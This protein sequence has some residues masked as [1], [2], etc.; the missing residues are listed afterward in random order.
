M[1]DT[2]KPINISRY[3]RT[4]RATRTLLLC[5]ALSLQS[6]CIGIVSNP[7]DTSEGGLLGF[8]GLLARTNRVYVAVGANGAAYTSSDGLTWEQSTVVADTSID[9]ED[10]VWTGSRFIAV[11]GSATSCG[12]FLSADGRT[13]ENVV[14]PSCT[15]RLRGVAASSDGTRV[16]TV[17]D[18]EGGLP[19]AFY[20]S[21]GGT[22]WASVTASGTVRYDHVVFALNQFMAF[23][24][25]LNAGALDALAYLSDGTTN[26]S[27]TPAVPFLT[28]AKGQT[29]GGVFVSG[30]RI[31]MTGNDPNNATQN[32]RSSTTTNLGSSWTQDTT[33][34]FNSTNTDFPRALALGDSGRLVALGDGCRLDFTSDLINLTWSGTTL[35]MGGCSNVNWA[36][37]VFDSGSYVAVGSTPANESFAAI[38]TSGDAS[39][40]TIV[41]LASAPIDGLA[42]SQ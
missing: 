15:T 27:I 31:I 29:L 34:I 39:S 35:T 38:S 26:F 36:D 12:I 3:F 20:S 21:D 13:W 33:L 23:S 9:V 10:V 8:L 17:G 19:K 1:Y 24:N 28:A 22:T 16:M 6:A 14:T 25:P 7:L 42:I 11:G 41:S 30:E 32:M 2:A 18:L 4:G 5:V 40:W 37:M